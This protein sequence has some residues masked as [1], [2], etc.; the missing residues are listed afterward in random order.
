M[1]KN[2][3]K[4]FGI[5]LLI[6]FAC[7]DSSYATAQSLSQHPLAPVNTRSP[8]STLEQ[9]ITNLEEAYRIAGD[10]GPTGESKF[11]LHRA[12]RCLNLAST[13]VEL[14]KSRGL[15]RALMLK[16][17]LDRVALPQLDEIPGDEEIARR[18]E[19]N[20]NP[21]EDWT[22]RNTEIRIALVN[23]GPRRGEY[24]FT[25]ETVRRVPDFYE[26]VKFLPYKV[27]TT[28]NIFDAYQ[29]TPGSGLD[30][31]WEQR[32]PDWAQREFAG[33][34]IWQWASGLLLPKHTAS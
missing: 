21:L 15:E 7:F 16:E 12:S 11:L 17:I 31:T 2:S 25:E 10:D 28:K 23:E 9:F 26:R 32:I 33:Q 24:L 29:L 20:E 6:S 3:K 30:L 4:L 5:V 18:A 1:L 27:D 22:I 34:A 14:R 13:P 19:E 8:R